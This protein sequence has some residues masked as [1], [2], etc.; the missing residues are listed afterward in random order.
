MDW[1]DVSQVTDGFK[2]DMVREINWD[3]INEYK[4]IN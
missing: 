3:M 4:I 1:I 2:E